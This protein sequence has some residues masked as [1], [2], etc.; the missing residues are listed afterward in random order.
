[1]SENSG[2]LKHSVLSRSSTSTL[3]K[4]Q[5][6]EKQMEALKKGREKRHQLMRTTPVIEEI[7]TSYKTDETVN[8]EVKHPVVANDVDELDDKAMMKAIKKKEH[9]MKMKELDLKMSK[10]EHDYSL[11][12]KEEPNQHSLSGTDTKGVRKEEPTFIFRN[13]RQRIII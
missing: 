9:D 3:P 2:L 6:S 11:P 1:M 4:R 13:Q 12:K 10:L 7:D 8:V 5:M